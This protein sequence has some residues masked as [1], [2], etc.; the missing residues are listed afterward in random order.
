MPEDAA[1]PKVAAARAYGASITF[2]K[3]T[4]E[5]RALTL[6]QVQ[7][8]TGAIFIPPYDAVNTMLGQGTTFLEMEQQCREG[9]WGALGA[10]I[11]PVGGGGLLGGIST[12]AK[13]TG[14]RVFGAGARF[15]ASCAPCGGS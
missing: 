3:P 9:G 10:V 4:A 5:A 8:E 12:A 1:R 11:A 2:C 13:G 7:K 6:A 14:V 15:H